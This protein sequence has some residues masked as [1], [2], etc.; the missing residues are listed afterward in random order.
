[1]GEQRAQQRSL[2]HVRSPR[3]RE[4]GPP[5][6]QRRDTAARA[7]RRFQAISEVGPFWVHSLHRSFQSTRHSA[8]FLEHA[9]K[10]WLLT[11]SLVLFFG[12]HHNAAQDMYL[13]R[14]Q[15]VAQRGQKPRNRVRLLTSIAW[16][17]V[18]TK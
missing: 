6:W 1:M 15:S 18:E 10:R 17:R 8:P 4:R 5:D 11:A 16:R 12:G 9:S 2:R 7:L 14:L 3:H 13:P